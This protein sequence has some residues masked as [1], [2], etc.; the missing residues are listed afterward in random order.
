MQQEVYPMEQNVNL[1]IQEPYAFNYK[2]PYGDSHHLALS[3]DQLSPTI[4]MRCLQPNQNMK[5]S[6]PNKFFKGYQSH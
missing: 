6:C 1:P 2:N 3:F 4:A 5:T